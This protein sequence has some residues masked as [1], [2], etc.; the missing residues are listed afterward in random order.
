MIHQTAY[1]ENRTPRSGS[2]LSAAFINP[3]PASCIRSDIGAPYRLNLEAIEID[4]I[5]SWDYP[6]FAD[7]FILY[8]EVDGKA[9]TVKQLEEV[10]AEYASEVHELALEL[11][12]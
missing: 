6:D 2:N 4:G 9:L 12:H 3:R 1:V 7:A 10:Q 5:N 8:A 11:A